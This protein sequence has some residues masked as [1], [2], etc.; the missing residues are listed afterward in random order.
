[1]GIENN[2]NGDGDEADAVAVWLRDTVR[3]PQYLELFESEGFDELEVLVDLTDPLLKQIGIK[4]MGHR[5]KIMKEIKKL[6]QAQEHQNDNAF[7]NDNDD[8]VSEANEGIPA[9]VGGANV[10]DTLGQY[11]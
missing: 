8:A 3:L 4:K 1:M 6:N 10:M 7:N 11:E 2:I 5:M 9:H